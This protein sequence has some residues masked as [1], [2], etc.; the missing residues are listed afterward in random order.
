VGVLFVEGGGGTGGVR[1]A[2]VGAVGMEKT[3]WLHGR[4]GVVWLS[5]DLRGLHGGVVTLAT[6]GL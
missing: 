3:K 6:V 5:G 4:E 2:A 1:R